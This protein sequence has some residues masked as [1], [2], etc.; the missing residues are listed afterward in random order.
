MGNTYIQNLKDGPFC[1]GKAI[2]VT[3]TGFQRE[4]VSACVECEQCNASTALYAIEKTAI[5]AWNMRGEQ[6]T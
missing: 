3:K 2:L 4:I 5:K 1:G 6:C